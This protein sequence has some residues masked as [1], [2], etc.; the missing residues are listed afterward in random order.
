MLAALL[1]HDIRDIP[2]RLLLAS[3]LRR[4]GRLEEAKRQLDTLGRFE[5]AEKWQLEIQRER[6]LILYK[7]TGNPEESNRLRPAA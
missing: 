1:K 3:L 6:Q 4:V 7:P 2:A 5:A